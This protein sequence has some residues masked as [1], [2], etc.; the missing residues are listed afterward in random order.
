M[1]MRRK[2]R[3]LAVQALY[4][5]DLGEAATLPWLWEQSS[6]GPRAKE[7]GQELV[8]GVTANLETIDDL[9]REAAEHWRLDRLSRVDL[10]VLR[11]AAYELKYRPE[12]PMAV[13]LDEAIELARYFG[14]SDSARFVNGVLDQVATGLGV[15]GGDHG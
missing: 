8:T 4:Q 6:A 5:I 14:T 9:I 7:F 15:K 13:V 3:Q 10:N 1:G 2:G 11:L 12:T